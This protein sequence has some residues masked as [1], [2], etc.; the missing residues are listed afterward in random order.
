LWCGK[1][2]GCAS[3]KRFYVLLWRTEPR[4]DYVSYMTLTAE[5]WEGAH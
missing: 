2:Y 4:P 5:V 3:T 1:E